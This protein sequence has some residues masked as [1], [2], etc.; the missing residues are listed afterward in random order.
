MANPGKNGA[1]ESE[2]MALQACLT[3]PSLWHQNDF[4]PFVVLPPY[5]LLI[6][7]YTEV[8][9]IPYVEQSCS[10]AADPRLPH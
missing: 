7:S 10:E 9:E 4:H 1:S 8:C 5:A 6:F 2:L 3:L